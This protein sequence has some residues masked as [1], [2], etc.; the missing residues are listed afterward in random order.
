MDTMR[1]MTRDELVKMNRQ[2]QEMIQRMQS[3]NAAL[4]EVII[5][6]TMDRYNVR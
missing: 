2:L 6:M 5:R 3:D 1:E 4:K